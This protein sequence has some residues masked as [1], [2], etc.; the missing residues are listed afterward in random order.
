MA[1]QKIQEQAQ[2]EVV[3][4][5]VRQNFW[6]KAST[7]AK[8]REL[9]IWAS[10]H[11]SRRLG[12][13]AIPTVESIFEI[14][15]PSLPRFQLTENGPWQVDWPIFRRDQ[16]CNLRCPE[17]SVFLGVMLVLKREKLAHTIPTLLKYFPRS[18]PH[19]PREE[20]APFD[21]PR[22]EAELIKQVCR[23]LMDAERGRSTPEELEAE[24][25]RKADRKAQRRIQADQGYAKVSDRDGAHGWPR[26]DRRDKPR[27]V[28]PSDG[29]INEPKSAAT[30][31]DYSL[32]LTV[33]GAQTNAMR[34][35]S[36]K[37]R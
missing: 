5:K 24:K 18:G 34:R 33:R 19:G 23:L 1:A 11:E 36:G 2:L 9:D 21:I 29:I 27:P 14:M 10:V 8:M 25:K 13:Q 17:E 3:D 16:T 7:H 28:P 37:H 6:G 15:P 26:C 32:D 35:G 20:L 30:E 12:L 22:F 31:L 4:G